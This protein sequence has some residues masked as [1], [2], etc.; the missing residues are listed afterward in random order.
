MS[1]ILERRARR[2]RPASLIENL[3][4]RAMKG[5]AGCELVDREEVPQAESASRWRAVK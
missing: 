3:G 5:Y 4:N 2:I 1:L